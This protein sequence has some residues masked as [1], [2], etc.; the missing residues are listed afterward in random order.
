MSATVYTVITDG[1]DSNRAEGVEVLTHYSGKK[2]SREGKI[3][4]YPPGVSIYIDG[5]MSL[6]EG[7]KE[8]LIKALGD[9]DIGLTRH[10][11]RDDVWKEGNAVVTSGLD[12]ATVVNNQLHR[13]Q[14]EGLGAGLWAC[15]VMVR[16]SSPRLAD[17]MQTW[18]REV[19]QGSWRDQLSFPYAMWK[20]PDVKVVDIGEHGKYV[21]MV[22]H[23]GK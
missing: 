4:D 20:H 3:L 2:G 23:G 5:N 17:M 19:E 9:A 10:W 21:S 13:Y 14:R 7:A 12:N 8:Q 15:G 11:M 22:P 16:R 18:W 6:K 1:Y